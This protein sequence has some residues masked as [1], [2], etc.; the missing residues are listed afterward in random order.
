[1]S[2]L[3]SVVLSADERAWLTRVVRTGAH[4]AQEVRRSRILLELDESQGVPAGRREIAERVGVD[5]D[6]VTNVARAYAERGGDIAAT[7]QR[8][9]RL[10]PPIEPK[11]T[12]EVEARLIALACSTP[13]PGHGRWSL[14]LLERQVALVADLPDMDHSTIGRV[15]KKRR[16]V[17]T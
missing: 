1:M 2:G 4:P 11:I 15:L 7:I 16:F 13:P 14:R 8:R 9:R 3:A 12:G 17:L 6:T 10:T 5:P